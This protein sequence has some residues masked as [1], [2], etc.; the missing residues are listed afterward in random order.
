MH[1]HN[2]TSLAV[3]NSLSAVLSGL[4]VVHTT[5]NGLGEFSG[6]AATEALS[7]AIDIHAGISLG[8]NYNKLQ[9][10]RTLISQITGIKKPPF[11]PITGKS[12]LAIPKTVEKPQFMYSL[13]LENKN[14][15]YLFIFK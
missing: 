5:I 10:A 7:A 12:A 15:K 4:S 1:P 14:V 13:S 6:L 2:T 8:L 3:A 9:V 11:N